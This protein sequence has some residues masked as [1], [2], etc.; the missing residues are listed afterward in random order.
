M[1]YISL[2]LL[3][4]LMIIWFRPIL[5]LLEYHLNKKYI[6][7]VLCQNI[8]KPEILCH[9]KCYLNEQIKKVNTEEETS[10]VVIKKYNDTNPFILPEAHWK[11]SPVVIKKNKLN[12]HSFI[13]NFLFIK[14]I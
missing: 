14:D 11:K 7:T 2:I 5:P 3:G 4:N 13:Y 10:K 6:A 1:K 12:L 9:G 8:D